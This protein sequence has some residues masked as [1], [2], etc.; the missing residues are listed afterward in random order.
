MIIKITKLER[1]TCEGFAHAREESSSLYKKRG[2]FKSEDIVSGAMGEIA[3][4]KLL[5]KNGHTLRKPDFEIYDRRNKSFDSD[6]RSGNKHFHVKSQT[7]KSAE[8]YGKSWL[9]QRNDPLFKNEGYNHYLVTT[10]VDLDKNT[11]EV[12]GFFPMFSVLKKNLIGE[13]KVPW[14]QKTKVALYHDQLSEGITE[15]QRWRVINE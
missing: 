11:V 5:K 8:Q 12:L 3:V 4:Y 9:C 13:C 14:F 15:Y 7:T 10:V 6:L 1:E 2:G